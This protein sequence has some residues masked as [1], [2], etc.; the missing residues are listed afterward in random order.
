MKPQP[1]NLELWLQL[2]KPNCVFTRNGDKVKN[3]THYDDISDIMDDWTLTGII[4]GKN[5]NEKILSLWSSKGEH[6]L[7]KLMR[8][9]EMFGPDDL[10]LHLPEKK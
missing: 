8:P 3:L 4:I 2:G 5:T 7:Y 1:F 6:H 10:M 9:Y